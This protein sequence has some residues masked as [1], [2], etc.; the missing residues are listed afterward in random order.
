[1]AP[2]NIIIIGAGIAGLSATIALRKQGHKITLLEK[3]SFL[4]EAGA[5]I[6]VSPN[7]TRLLLRLGLDT[8][9]FGGNSCVGFAQYD[10]SGALKKRVDMRTLLQSFDSPFDLIH[11]ADLHDALKKLALDETG[12][13][14]VPELLLGCRIQDLDTAAGTVSLED[15]STFRGDVIIGADGVH[16]FCRKKIDSSVRPFPYGKSCY[17]W[18]V[19]RATLLADPE[20]APLIEEEGWFEEFSEG[21]RRLVMYPCRHNVAMNV[22]AFVPDSD[23]QILGEDCDNSTT[24]GRLNQSFK[25]FSAG[26]QKI[27]SHASEDVGLWTL[28]DMQSPPTWTKDRLVLIGDAAHPFLPFLGQG[29][30]MAIE[31]GICLARLLL[32]ETPTDAVY[33]RLQMF[34]QLRYK[35]VEFVRDETRQNGLD[36]GERP[37]NMYPMMTYCYEHDAWTHTENYLKASLPS[38]NQN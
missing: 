33:E 25:N 35:R 4:Q 1:M 31:D 7:C 27:V 10:G 6:H 15:K 22:A 20:I 8:K 18:M 28:H 2:L 13:G 5:A 12:D 3:S 23:I 19:P 34:E 14:P 36:E 24:R 11:R 17:R 21:N 30:A 32:P 9:K 38:N 16:S 37:N 26:V 29:G